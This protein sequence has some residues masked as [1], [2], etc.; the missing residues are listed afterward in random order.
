MDAIAKVFRNGNS[1]AVRI[2]TEFRLES[3]R[4]R[5]ER[6]EHGDLVL[7]PLPKRRGDALLAALE[8][9]DEAFVEAL[10]EDRKERLPIQGRE[11]L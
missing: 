9:F 3:D 10:E 11:A 1:Q 7:H 4:V 8:G 5:I 2:P 6:N